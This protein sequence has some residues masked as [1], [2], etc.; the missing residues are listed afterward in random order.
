MS[1]G[2]TNAHNLLVSNTPTLT[3]AECPLEVQIVS[4]VRHKRS[5]TSSLRS[6]DIARAKTTDPNRTQCREGLISTVTL[7]TQSS[8]E[9]LCIRWWLHLPSFVDS[10]HDCRFLRPKSPRNKLWNDHNNPCHKKGQL[11]F[12]VLCADRSICCDSQVILL[13]ELASEQRDIQQRR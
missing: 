2:D 10:N 11:S 3:S 8:D 6:Y 7:P 13:N 4:S 1:I 9:S 5:C 12:A